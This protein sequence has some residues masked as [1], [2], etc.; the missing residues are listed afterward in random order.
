VKIQGVKSYDY[1]P[2]EQFQ[3]LNTRRVKVEIVSS[4]ACPYR[5]H[6]CISVVYA[7]ERRAPGVEGN[8]QE[9]ST[10]A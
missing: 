8:S 3:V 1:L 10:R 9:Q 2:I 7:V 6:F 5:V 4:S